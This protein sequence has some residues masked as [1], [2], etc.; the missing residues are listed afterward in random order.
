MPD[1]FEH[2]VGQE[3]REGGC[4]LGPTTRAETSFLT[5]R[6]YQ[7]LVTAVRTSDTCKARLKSAAVQVGV[8]DIVDEDPPEAVAALKA[9]L[10]NALDLA[11]NCLDEAVQRR[12]LWLARS[13]ETDS[14]FCDQ[15]KLLPVSQRGRIN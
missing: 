2:F 3:S 4:P 14:A 1:L 7:E 8:D 10:P 12:F 15:G 11:V 9:L 13:I 5:A 6:R